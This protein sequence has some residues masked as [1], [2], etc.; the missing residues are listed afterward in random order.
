MQ[1]RW[2]SLTVR[3]ALL[4]VLGSV[5]ACGGDDLD[6]GA[7]NASGS[8]TGTLAVDGTA[9][10]SPHRINAQLPADFDT[11]FSVRVSLDN[12]TVTTGSVAI[13]SATGKI[14]LTLHSDGRWSGSV[15]GYDQ[16]YVLDVATGP[17]AVAGVRV[18]GPDLHVFLEPTEGET[19]DATSELAIAWRCEDR[20]DTAVLRAEN[21]DA[22]EIPDTGSYTLAPGGLKTE[23]SQPRPNTLRLTRSNRVVPRGGAA[24]SSWTV[25]IDNA[26]N[27]VAK[28][29]GL[30]L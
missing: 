25:A 20:A 18:D 24:G 10:A 26:I 28:A 8:G 6:P 2:P 21:I 16:V 23:R 3:G 15:P 22:V 27:V 1:T 5:V 7:G 4:G 29:Q 14:P 12:Q 17:D 19:V 9:H 13:T 30:P 11:E